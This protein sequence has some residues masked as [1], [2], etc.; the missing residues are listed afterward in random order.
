MSASAA[1][2]ARAAAEGLAAGRAFPVERRASFVA[3][4]PAAMEARQPDA[5]AARPA[6]DGVARSPERLADR[7]GAHAR[8]RHD[9]NLLVE[10][11]LVHS[12]AFAAGSAAKMP[13][14]FSVRWRGRGSCAGNAQRA[15]VGFFTRSDKPV[16]AE[17]A[18]VHRS[19][20]AVLSIIKNRQKT[21]RSLSPRLCQ[22]ISPRP[23]AGHCRRPARQMA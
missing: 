3:R 9:G 13:S 23:Q 18:R 7:A 15:R 2:A 20:L 14:R 10:G 11:L 4:R 22:G 1:A 21:G 12:H 5:L 17:G 8:L 19:S 16:P 6:D